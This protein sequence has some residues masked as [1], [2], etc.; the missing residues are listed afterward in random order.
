[1]PLRQIYLPGGG[2]GDIPPGSS[3]TTDNLGSLKVNADSFETNL[4]PEELNFFQLFIEQIENNSNPTIIQNILAE[5]VSI[6]DI[7]ETPLIEQLLILSTGNETNLLPTDTQ[8]IDV[9]VNNSET[10]ISPNEGVL[11]LNLNTIETNNDPTE[12][13]N[14]EFTVSGDN[15]VLPNE[16][17]RSDIFA[18]F[19][20]NNLLPTEGVSPLD[21]QNVEE[22]NTI[23]V[24]GKT[25]EAL[26]GASAARNGTAAWTNPGN[27][28]GVNN[29][30]LATA[31]GG[32]TA[33]DVQLL[34]DYPDPV[35][36]VAITTVKLRLYIRQT[37]TTLSN[38]GLNIL[39]RTDGV[40][41]WQTSGYTS[42]FLN[43]DN[44]DYL[45]APLIVDITSLRT[46]TWTLINN[47]VVAAQFSVAAAGTGIGAAVDAIIL[48]ITT[49]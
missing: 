11:S 39:F 40:T 41:S 22:T 42:I 6:G 46:W 9:S 25:L 18:D 2:G 29:G 17:F 10:N 47:L 23:P 3:L 38:G 43:R 20:E 21:I 34:L 19:L 4:T 13:S 1:M 8:T 14:Y 45:T 44:F 27:A 24:E 26:A 7:N 49:P 28:A 15:N 12:S 48:E 16:S 5:M 33:V 30:T 31:S 37:G 32:L 36:T 35:T